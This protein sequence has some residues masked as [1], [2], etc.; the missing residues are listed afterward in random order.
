MY[1]T[2]LTEF[3]FFMMS[4]MA[5]LT[6]AILYDILR[7][8]RRFLKHCDAAVAAEDILF[9]AAFAG[10][11]FYAA[12]LK[13]S[14]EVRI[15]GFLGAAAGLLLYIGVIGNK[16]LNVSSAVIEFIIKAVSFV[17]RV[18]FF[19]LRVILKALKKPVSVV[20]WYTGRG[21]RRVGAGIKTEKM[22]LGIRLRCFFGFL[23]KNGKK[24]KKCIDKQNNM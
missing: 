10:I 18:V 23:R 22:R 4:V 5:G 3:E 17:L 13:N 14:G 20:A 8:G 24:N 1:P 9:F 15:Q 12:Y 6:A 11:L 19:P 16:L 2:V 21:A 7:I